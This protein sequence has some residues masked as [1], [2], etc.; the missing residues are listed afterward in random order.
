MNDVQHF[1][2]SNV[3]PRELSINHN[4]LSNVFILDM[5]IEDKIDKNFWTKQ[6]RLQVNLHQATKQY[7]RHISPITFFYYDIQI[8]QLNTI[9]R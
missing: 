8:I 7:T 5:W 2:S 1:N 9:S 4:A 3:T 6:L